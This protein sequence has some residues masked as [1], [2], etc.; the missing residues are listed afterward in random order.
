MVVESE[1]FR[2]RKRFCQEQ[3][4]C[5]F[6]TTNIGDAGAGF[7]FL[8]N[9]VERRDPGAHKIGGVSGAKELFAPV[10][11]PVVVFVPAH[12]R[13]A[14]ERL[15][16]ARYC[17]QRPEGELEGSRQVRWAVFAGE[18][19]RL[20]FSQTESIR[21]FIVSDIANGGLPGQPLAK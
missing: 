19:E 14:A 20:F 7:E 9:A 17:G 4:R 12:A 11:N 1:E 5:A 21:C 15:R 8:F 2:V 10:E 6:S 18:R 13:P 3:G 16:D